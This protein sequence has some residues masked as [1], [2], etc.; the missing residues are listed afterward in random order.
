M[1]WIEIVQWN[2][3]YSH[4]KEFNTR[5]PSQVFDW[6]RI[7]IE[8]PLLLYV[9]PGAEQGI[10][11]CVCYI[12]VG[13]LVSLLCIISDGAVSTENK[14]EASLRLSKSH[15]M[16]IKF[17]NLSNTTRNKFMYDTHLFS[18]RWSTWSMSLLRIHNEII[19][20]NK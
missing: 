3:F 7:W 6:P 8:G 1:T 10:E 16:K 12:G 11:S 13:F 4:I 14:C 20:N 17:T 9:W 18:S 5:A 2:H 15:Y 19:R